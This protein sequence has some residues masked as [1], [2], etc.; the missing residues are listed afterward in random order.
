MLNYGQEYAELLSRIEDNISAADAGSL[1]ATKFLSP[2]EAFYAKQIICTL[3]MNG[4]SLFLGGYD[5]A[6]RVRLVILPSYLDG[7][8]EEPKDML[9]EYFPEEAAALVRVIK[10]R[11][12]GFVSLSHKDYMGSILG[13]GVERDALGDIIV[14]D[15]HTSYAF[16]LDSIAGLMLGSLERIGRDKVNLEMT[17]LDEDFSYKRKFQSVSDTVASARLDCVV[18]AL[19]NLSREKAQSFIGNGL[20]LL[21]YAEEL[22][23]DRGV[24]EGDIITLRGYGK[25]IIREIH[26]QTKKGRLRLL[27]DKYV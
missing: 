16:V 17:E 5:D 12:S 6:E 27:A 21:N 3:G 9:F 22:R 7:L 15:E 13:L 25:F 26:Q 23:C 11:G 24:G 18:A 1:A 19:A 20:C 4:R 10:I 8:G 14:I 2:A